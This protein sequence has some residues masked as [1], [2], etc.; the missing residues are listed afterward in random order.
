MADQ[1]QTQDQSQ[2]QAKAPVTINI[3]Q[4]QT[5]QP[6]TDQGIAPNGIPNALLANP[7]AATA[8]TALP[9]QS[10]PTAPQAPQP[11]PAAQPQAPVQ[12]P[13]QPVQVKP[14][15]AP[16]TPVQ[17]FQDTKVNTKNELD[18]EAKAWEQD[19][20]NGHIKPETYSELFGKK[21]TLGKV[22]TLFGLM[23]G[24]VGSG[25]THQPNAVMAMMD[26]EIANDFDAQK[27]SKA[28]A[29]NFLRLHQEMGLNQAKIAQMQKEGKL[30]DAQAKNL[31]AETDAKTFANANNKATLASFHYLTDQVN[32]M[33]QGPQ[34]QQAEQNLGLLYS[35]M[36][37]KIANT[38]DMAAGAAAMY[39]TLG[40]NAGNGGSSEEQFQQQQMG[41]RMLGKQG[42]DMAKQ[43]EEK[44][45]PGAG[46]SS[47]NISPENRKDWEHMQN[48]KSSYNDAN[49]YLDNSHKFGA[50]W[51][52]AHKAQGQAL[53]N[54]MELEVGQ[55]EG[56]GR[57]TPEEAKRYKGLIPDLTGTHFTGQDKAKLDSLMN[58]V[59]EHVNNM[60]S[61]LGVVDKKGSQQKTESPGGGPSEG[62][63]ATSKSG[64][65]MVFKN[66]NWMYK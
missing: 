56:L 35:K 8:Q 65:P 23:L 15:E 33:P 2:D 31:A 3:G 57:F 10:Q 25:L 59:N 5:G 27:Q 30:N 52:N 44:H 29:Q 32:K 58:E 7:Q 17:A 47:I 40:L 6:P 45:L 49:T 42:E 22:G 48:L 20:Q 11:M 64:K 26:K 24:G 18:N 36:G 28:N 37:E 62:Q 12:A 53:E 4:P 50:G 39:K 61:S 60:K 63:T 13:P 14:P 46:Q 43:A 19:L 38:N 21:D 34:R 41:R 51:Q 16:A 54:R 55:L 1:D 66:G 9:Q